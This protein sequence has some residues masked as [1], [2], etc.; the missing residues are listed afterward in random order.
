MG[1]K[2]GVTML[3][4]TLNIFLYLIPMLA[5]WRKYRQFDFYMLI[6]LLYTMTAT[7]CAF[8]YYEVPGEY[9]NITFFPFLYLF[10][11][12]MIMFSP[13]RGKNIGANSFIIRDNTAFKFLSWF[14][15]IMSFVSVYLSIPRIIE[16][17]QSGDWGAIRNLLGD[18]NEGIEHYAS[19]GERLVKN[20]SSYLSPFALVYAFYQLTKPR[21]SRWFVF[22]LFSAI[23]IPSFF[24]ASVEASRGMIMH[25][26]IKL[27]IA[28]FMFRF[29]IPKSRKKVIYILSLILASVFI[30]YS[31]A[32]TVSR[33]G[34]DDANSSLFMYFGH[35]ML[36]FNDGIFNSM[37]DYAGG[38]R[39]F[40]WFIDLFGGDSSF[41]SAKLGST[42]GTAFFTIV[43]G[44]FIDWGPYGTVV[45]AII[46]C[47]IANIWFKK[48]TYR[49]SDSIFLVFYLSTLANG[50]FVFGKGRALDWFM[51]FV[52]FLI[53]RK[54]EKMK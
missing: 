42:A 22:L 34:E 40:S 43:G 17:F 4:V 13:V 18:D 50:I 26:V 10:V 23:V 33:F 25:L 14:F 15:I 41:S 16:T 47:I 36:A 37:H 39:F 20:L 11:V 5:Y 27:G 12:L 19:Q 51:T 31:I 38:K 48:K 28:Y 35:S 29:L 44:M 3:A 24:E 6:L 7:M 21:F 2:N 30:V 45:V 49:L 1:F 53:V 32:V 46:A 54:I 8:F 52:L 9:K